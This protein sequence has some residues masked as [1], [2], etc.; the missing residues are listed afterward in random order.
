[1]FT[2]AGGYGRIT[3]A[4]ANGGRGIA[5]GIDG[6]HRGTAAPALGRPQRESVDFKAVSQ[7]ESTGAV[8]SLSFCDSAC[9]KNETRIAIAGSACTL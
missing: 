8:V 2:D 3:A 7:F 1:M 5:P 6:S 9:R 4:G